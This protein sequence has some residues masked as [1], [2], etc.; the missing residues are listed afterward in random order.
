MVGAAGKAG[1]TEPELC[2]FRRRSSLECSI[3]SAAARYTRALALDSRVLALKYLRLAFSV[4]H[5]SRRRSVLACDSASCPGVRWVFER[6][7]EACAPKPK[8]WKPPPPPVDSLVPL[9]SLSRC[10]ACLVSLLSTCFSSQVL[11]RT[12][13]ARVQ[14]RAFGFKMLVS[15]EARTQNG[16]SIF[17]A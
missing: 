11:K 15:T 7:T 4:L 6:L 8:R 2:R 3:D 10:C 17:Y 13:Q 12:C 16:I 9:V 5:L 1:T 14:N